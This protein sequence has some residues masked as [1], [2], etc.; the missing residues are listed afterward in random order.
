VTG[1]VVV[2][3]GGAV[4]SFLAGVLA[5][6]GHPV[7]LIDRHATAGRGSLA[8]VG[9]GDR[10]VEAEVDRIPSL[11]AA[12]EAVRSP[13]LVVLAVKTFDLRG[14]IDGCAPWPEAPILTI[15]NG[16]GAEDVVAEQRPGAPLIAGSLTTP[17]EPIPGGV[18]WRRRGGLALAPAGDGA[19]V[20]RTID[21]ILAATAAIGLPARRVADARAMKWSKLLANLI[22]NATSALVDED[23]RA[24][25]GDRRLFAMERRQLLE[26]LAVMAALD[27]EPI[28][29][30][31]ADGRLLALAVRLPEPVS[32][33]VLRRVVGRA[34]GGKMPSLRL[35]LRSAVG[36]PS[37]VGWLNGAVVRWGERTGVSTPV[38]RRL[39]EL[40]EAV[41]VD[42]ALRTELRGHPELVAAAVEA[43]SL[44]SAMM[45][46][47]DGQAS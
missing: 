43:A 3:G 1:P 22:G 23:V 11:T 31:G 40:V 26:A 20:E 8:I 16:V 45:H 18:A 5:A 24:V 15:Q 38:N 41:L 25:Y 14:A 35:H 29:L 30:P 27:L 33:T 37:E 17:L 34:R 9:R 12:G 36:P 46:R 28:A 39:T 7:T 32:R 42:R 13:E 6:G 10:R 2:V 44:E 21:A 19:E 4:G 47:H